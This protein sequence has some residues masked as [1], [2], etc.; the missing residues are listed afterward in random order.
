MQWFG[1]T[2]WQAV[3]YLFSF[4]SDLYK[5]IALTLVVSLSALSIATALALPFAAWLSLADN[6]VRRVCIVMIHTLMGFPPVVAG[7]LV[8]LLLSRQGPLG[9]L[10]WL[11]SP[12]AM[13]IAQVI[14]IFPIVCGL[15]QQVFRQRQMALSDLFYSL[16][17]GRAK[18]LQTIITESRFQILG[19]L[20]AGL[21][22]G[23]AEVGAVMIVGGN[24]FHHDVAFFQHTRTITTAIALETSQGELVTAVS[25]GLV[26]LIISLG[27]NLLLLWFN[28]HFSE[29][30]E[31]V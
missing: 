20:V 31:A 3:L 23:L 4:D 22:R 21:G 6:R 5:I 1:E 15:S 30:T 19:A 16:Q 26:L 8:Y 18:R 10:G 25:L 17:L 7:L 2:L 12:S 14:L 24:L 27:L 13:V 29:S 11:F 28:R 9:D